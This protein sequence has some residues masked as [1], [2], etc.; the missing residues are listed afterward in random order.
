MEAELNSSI[1]K[2][3][4]HIKSTTYVEN[5]KLE[6]IIVKNYLKYCSIDSN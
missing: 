3:T 6:S 4:F 5:S 1:L 2:C